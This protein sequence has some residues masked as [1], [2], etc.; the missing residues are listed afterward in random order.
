MEKG[1]SESLLFGNIT[2]QELE[3]ASIVLALPFAVH[4]RARFLGSLDTGRSSRVSGNGSLVRAARLLGGSATGDGL[5]PLRA[6]IWAI[7][8]AAKPLSAL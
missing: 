2:Q 8:L 3:E 1:G 7:C 4:R 6:V 5:A